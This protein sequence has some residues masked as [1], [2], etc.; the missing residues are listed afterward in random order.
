MHILP[1]ALSTTDCV[2]CTFVNKYELPDIQLL[3]LSI[4]TGLLNFFFN[5]TCVAQLTQVVSPILELLAVA[6]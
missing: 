2:I 5:H 4:I 3:K 6:R 1:Q